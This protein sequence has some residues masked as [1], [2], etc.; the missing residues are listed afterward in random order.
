M[1]ARG[2]IGPDVVG[3]PGAAGRGVTLRE[4]PGGDRWIVSIMSGHDRKGRWRI[5]GKCTVLN[6]MGG[7]DIKLGDESVPPGGPLI[8]IRVVSIMAGC[9][10]SRGRKLS[11]EERK[12]QKELRKAEGRGELDS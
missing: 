10:V 5:A 9:G 4:G 7:N 6:I 2:S 3:Q 1:T 11:R 12:R 8:R